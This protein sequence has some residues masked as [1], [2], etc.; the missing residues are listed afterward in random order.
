[1]ITIRMSNRDAPLSS[2]EPAPPKLGPLKIPSAR[3]RNGGMLIV[4]VCLGSLFWPKEC[5]T[6]HQA[7]GSIFEQM[8]GMASLST[9]GS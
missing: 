5:A 3:A 6:I 9:T 4:F 2:K 7:L 1:M 8:T